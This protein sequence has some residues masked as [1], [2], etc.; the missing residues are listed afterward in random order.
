MIVTNDLVGLLTCHILI[1]VDSMN[2]FL[3]INTV[4]DCVTLQRDINIFANWCAQNNL[5]LNPDKCQV[6][7]FCRSSMIKFDYTIAGK[8]LKRVEFKKD[9]GVIFDRQ[10]KFNHHIE[11]VVN[12]A[13]KTTGFL[14]R[15]SRSFTSISTLKRLFL[16]LVRP[17]LNYA[18]VVWSPNGT[19]M[20]T[21]LEKCQRRFA[22]FLQYKKTGQYPPRGINNQ[23]LYNIYIYNTL[24]LTLLNNRRKIH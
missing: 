14:I 7:T 17:K 19:T 24:S 1:Y 2:I 8:V 21:A 23:I 4:R 11:S 10:L 12:A 9:L 3:P 5:Y 13:N 16:T 6:M 20:R 18:D 15:M 22:K